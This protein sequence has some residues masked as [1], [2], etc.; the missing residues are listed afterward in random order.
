V[1]LDVTDENSIKEAIQSILSEASRIDLLV[2]DAGYALKGAF[3]DNCLHMVQ[4]TTITT[5]NFMFAYVKT[6][7]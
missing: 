6:L 4:P 2:N 3:E 1:Q 5:D 7:R